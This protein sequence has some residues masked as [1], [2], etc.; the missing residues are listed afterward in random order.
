M[1]PRGSPFLVPLHRVRRGVRVALL[2]AATLSAAADARA[3]WLITPFLGA[4]FAGQTVHV[5]FEQGAGST[6]FVFGGAG[7]WLTDG[8]FGI[9]ADFAYAPPHFAR[10]PER[11]DAHRVRPLLVVEHEVLRV[12]LRTELVHAAGDL[13]VKVG[14]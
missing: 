8:I 10:D 1:G 5:D 14:S 12:G 7:A 2:V 6:Q 11:L 3:D 9:E 4:T 13:D